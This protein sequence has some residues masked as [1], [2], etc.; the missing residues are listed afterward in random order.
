MLT[1][2]TFFNEWSDTDHTYGMCFINDEFPALYIN[3]PKNAS[4]WTKDQIKHLKF[5][6]ANYHADG[7]YNYTNIF[8]ALRDPIDRWISGI[9][10]YMTLHHPYMLKTIK[11]DD[12]MVDTILALIKSRIHF[13]CHTNIQSRFISGLEISNITFF[14]I[15]NNSDHYRNSFSKFVTSRFGINNQFDR[16]SQKNVAE[17]NPIQSEWVKLFKNCV[18]SDFEFQ[19]KLKK[20]YEMDYKLIESVKFYE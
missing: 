18:E 15:E 9:S 7:L 4:S 16:V 11:D 12:K 20:F 1:N 19:E 2:Q 8:V 3:I 13:D 17:E 6:T 14:K 10:W 5:K